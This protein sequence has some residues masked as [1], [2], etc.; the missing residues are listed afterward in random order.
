MRSKISLNLFENI[1]ISSLRKIIKLKWRVT[2]P[3][4]I[5]AEIWNFASNPDKCCGA[6]TFYMPS[7]LLLIDF[8]CLTAFWLGSEGGMRGGWWRGG[9][10]GLGGGAR[11]HCVGDGATAFKHYNCDTCARY[12]EFTYFEA[13]GTELGVDSTSSYQFNANLTERNVLIPRVTVNSWY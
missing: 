7:F 3:V 6:C 5:T 2:I 4:I 11:F 12:V 8:V 13:K 10:Y 9:G 1:N